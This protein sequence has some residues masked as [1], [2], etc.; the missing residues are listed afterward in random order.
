MSSK[1]FNIAYSASTVSRVLVEI[2]NY[3]TEGKFKVNPLIIANEAEDHFLS[4][5]ETVNSMAIT[6]EAVNLEIHPTT[7]ADNLTYAGIAFAYDELGAEHIIQAVEH[8]INDVDS[9]DGITQ[10]CEIVTI[11]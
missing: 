5:A 3:K 11:A 10:I 2:G 6:T 8:H 7:V 9:L 4:L 1:Y